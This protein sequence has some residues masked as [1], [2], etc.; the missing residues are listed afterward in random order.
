MIASFGYA[1]GISQPFVEGVGTP[2]AGQTHINPGVIIHKREGDTDQ[3]SRPAWTQDGSI[4][5]FRVLE[6][7]VPEL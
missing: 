7:R 1:D 6:Q 5:A 4:M 3:A 2:S